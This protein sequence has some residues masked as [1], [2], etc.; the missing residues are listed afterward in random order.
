M[1]LITSRLPPFA[2]RLSMTWRVFWF[3]VGLLM[4]LGGGAS[5]LACFFWATGDLSNTSFLSELGAIV[6]IFPGLAV[7]AVGANIVENVIDPD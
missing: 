4:M 3:V 5:M 7:F 2:T 1:K 6:S